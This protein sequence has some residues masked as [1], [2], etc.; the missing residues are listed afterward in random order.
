MYDLRPSLVTFSERMRSIARN[1]SGAGADLIAAKMIFI[2]KTRPPQ[3][4]HI[5]LFRRPTPH[6]PTIHSANDEIFI[7]YFPAYTHPCTDGNVLLH[8][9]RQAARLPPPQNPLTTTPL[10][11][12]QPIVMERKE[13]SFSITS[14]DGSTSLPMKVIEDGNFTNEGYPCYHCVQKIADIVAGPNEV[15]EK[16]LIIIVN[17]EEILSRAPPKL[18]SQGLEIC[19]YRRWKVIVVR[20]RLQQYCFHDGDECM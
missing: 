2:P 15:V 5:T 3:S 20:A 16:S 11:G 9:T 14:L 1:I 6:S 8:L 18:C 13:H 17:D 19:Q 7:Q 10:A 4:S 12:L